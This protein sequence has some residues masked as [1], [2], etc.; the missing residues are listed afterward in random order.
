MWF[1]WEMNSNYIYKL[2]SGLPIDHVL[3]LLTNQ[4]LILLIN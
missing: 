2:E 4:T 1:T 3:G